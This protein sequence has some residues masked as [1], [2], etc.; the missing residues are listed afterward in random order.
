M[1]QPSR[2]PAGPGRAADPLRDSP[3]RRRGSTTK[4]SRSTIR[5]ITT[6]TSAIRHR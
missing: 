3:E 6:N 5:F 4:Y 2:Q 1:Q